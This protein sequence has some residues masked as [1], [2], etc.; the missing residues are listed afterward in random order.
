MYFRNLNLWMVLITLFI[1]MGC[2]ATRNGAELDYTASV[3]TTSYTYDNFTACAAS[4]GTSNCGASVTAT[5]TAEEKTGDCKALD[6][7][8][9]WTY[10]HSD[11]TTQNVEV[12]FGD[13]DAGGS[14]SVTKTITFSNVTILGNTTTDGE[15]SF[16]SDCGGY[17]TGQD[18]PL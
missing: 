5:Y 10:S 9:E 15:E 11:G 8:L 4:G 17:L 14:K 16:T 1:T 13:I 7:K 18:F 2:G 3:D 12:D 6:S